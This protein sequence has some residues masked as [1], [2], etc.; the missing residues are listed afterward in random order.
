MNDPLIQLLIDTQ[1]DQATTMRDNQKEQADVM[2]KIQEDIGAIKEIIVRATSTV[3]QMQDATRSLQ[4]EN[5][6]T[7]ALVEELKKFHSECPARVSHQSGRV[8]ANGMTT[9]LT[10]ILSLL[11]VFGICYTVI[12]TLKK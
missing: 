11:N 1:K 7:K 4:L 5:K 2:R 12:V 6:E 9:W 10:L 3:S 8:F